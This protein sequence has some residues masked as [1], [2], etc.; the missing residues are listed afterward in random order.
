MQNKR[1][2]QSFL[3]CLSAAAVILVAGCKTH[4]VSATYLLPAREVADVRSV[5]TI[6]IDATAKLAGNQAAA[7]DAQRVAALARQMLAAELYRRGFYR[8]EDAIW[9]SLDGAAGV[10][11]LVT[12]GG[13]RHGYS[14]FMTEES[15]A[16]ATLKLEIDL[17]YNVEKSTQRQ[18]YELTTTPYVI[19]RPK[20]LVPF[21]VPDPTATETRKVESSWDSWEWVGRGKLRVSLLPKNAAEP[22]YTRDFDLSVPSSAGIGVPPYLR[23]A[24]AALAPA[25]KEI[26]SD[27][28]P[29]YE[30][31]PLILSDGGDS[32]A[33]T[34]LEAGA[35]ADAIELIESIP[36]EKATIGDFENLGV[37]YEM[38]G[39]FRSASGAYERA[40]AKAPEN[41]ALRDKM[42]T[43]AKA[44]KARKDVRESG[45][46]ANEDT[47]FKAPA[48]K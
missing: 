40:L 37:A 8:V 7:D 38:M 32:R 10:G 42:N 20:G 27:I 18:T 39:D 19:K 36:A 33:M 43:L 23:A 26:V 12:L 35:F 47:S 11:H 14:V 2:F 16:K 9:G 29:S 31:R 44:A 24:T 28:S 15:P 3:A 22:V 1:S 41:E 5:D 45:A 46:K 25:I 13:S 17:S 4:Q 6:L 21:S 30:K 34:L 48:I